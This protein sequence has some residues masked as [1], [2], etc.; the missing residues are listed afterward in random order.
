MTGT[1]AAG[2]DI[3]RLRSS[4]SC[5]PECLLVRDGSSSRTSLLRRKVGIN[6]TMQSLRG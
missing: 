2:R 1:E 6:A 4:R 3:E 5:Q